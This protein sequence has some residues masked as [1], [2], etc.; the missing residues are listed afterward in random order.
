M[1]SLFQDLKYALRGLRRSPGFTVAAVAT[2]ALGLGANTAIFSIVNAVLLRPLPYESPNRIVTL[3][4]LAPSGQLEPV[5][6][7]NFLDWR[8]EARSFASLAAIH[9][10]G[11]N[12]LGVGEP[13][14]VDSASVSEG[15]FSETFRI[16]LLS[17]RG[18]EEADWRPE[19]TPV[20][21]VSERLWRG[22]FGSDPHLIGTVLRLGG[23][24]AT[25]VGIL[26]AGLGYPAAC[27][28]WM[29]LKFDSL[30]LKTRG[31]HF[32]ET[33]GRLAPGATL[34]EAREEM[35][36]IAHRL[37]N[38]YPGTNTDRG[39][40]VE[41]LGQRM[42]RG[43]RPAL[44]MLLAAVSCVL[45]IGCVNV[46]N[47]LLARA[48]VRRRE[49]AIRTAVGAGR[50]RLVRQLLTESLTLVSAGGAAGLL[51]ARWGADLLV[52]LAPAAPLER[53]PPARI[54]AAVLGA[55]AGLTALACVA[56]GLVPALEASRLGGLEPELRGSGSSSGGGL[57]GG[58]TRRALVATEVALAALLLVA[59][60]LMLRTFRA[61]RG[62]DP[63]FDPSHTLT[64]ELHLPALGVGDVDARRAQLFGLV[65]R[66]EALPGVR[67]ASLVL[68]PPMSGQSDTGNVRIEGV[69]PAARGRENVVEQRFVGPRYFASLGIPLI[70]G[71]DF[72]RADDGRAP[73][74]AIVNRAMARRY[75]PG[76]D[77]IGRRLAFDIIDGRPV[78]L[79]VVGLV[80]DVRQL[81]P[82]REPAAEVDIP[83]LQ[84]EP[85]VISF[86][87]PR[88][89]LSLLVRGSREPMALAGT[90]RRAIREAA[91]DVPA[92]RVRPMEALV[93]DAVADRR[94]E[95]F[96]LGAF[97]GFALTLAA[98]GVGGVVAFG[99]AR[100]RREMSIRVSLGATSRELIAGAVRETMGPVCAGLAV[101]LAA[102]AG[103]TRLLGSILFGV[104]PTDPVTYFAVAVLLA[105]VAALAAWLPARG[106]SRVDPMEALR[107]E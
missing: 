2:L 50:S 68:F 99:V 98:I 30:F 16:P 14:R 31:S 91:P 53:F 20:V 57:R 1:T 76:R 61:L 67:A 63:G 94:F 33:V 26:P 88:E 60:G 71:R 52:S 25:V 83:Y 36:V 75:W 96:V 65:D 42:A 58:R 87:G 19:A 97:A 44:W 74:V 102:A 22:V 3:E 27:D 45:L 43:L 73:G 107:A 100:R 95:W 15:F 11:V 80:G 85:E 59:G 41:L 54:D 46:A 64:V 10:E 39:V 62:V 78:W 17:G 90:V 79:K 32:L 56:A 34:A 40:Q 92:T 104:S 51:L 84:A 35:H 89:P 82:D 66:V 106:L 81:G 105:G 86:F 18:L 8:A 4:E 5:S 72:T 7:P 29:P 13:R 21:L 28:L 6:G 9:E 77:P 23:A 49:M 70:A 47:L 38:L 12:L 101:G 93:S 103:A 37:A 24:T 48:S 69:P 55:A